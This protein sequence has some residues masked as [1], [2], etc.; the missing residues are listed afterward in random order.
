M[1]VPQHG[2]NFLRNLVPCT[3]IGA[4][5]RGVVPFSAPLHPFPQVFGDI[6]PPNLQPTA[7]SNDQ[8]NRV[9]DADSILRLILKL[10][11]HG[12]VRGLYLPNFDALPGGLAG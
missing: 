2:L 5:I 9:M 7:P 1:I 3:P 12:S 4:A 11:N 6:L 8:R 10:P